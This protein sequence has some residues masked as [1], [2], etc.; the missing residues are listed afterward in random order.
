MTTPRFHPGDRVR[1]LDIGQPGHVRIP[2]YVR[3]QVGV[4]ERYCGAYPNPEDLAYGRRGLPPVDLY[5]V[6]F[7]QFALWPD[8]PGPPRDTLEIEV[9]DHWLAPAAEEA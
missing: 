3:R 5:R 1:V 9:Y 6:H 7:A 4:V 8:Y 2:F